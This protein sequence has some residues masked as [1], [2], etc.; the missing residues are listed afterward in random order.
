MTELE[1]ELLAAAKVSAAML[2]AVY[3]WLDK[4]NAAGGATS[5]SGVATCHAMLKSLESN[6][7]RAET[8]VMEPLR[9]AI[10]KASPT[11]ETSCAKN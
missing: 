3:Q 9:A 7:S 6:R 2:G 5:I 4:V 8:L 11:G 10:A 1:R